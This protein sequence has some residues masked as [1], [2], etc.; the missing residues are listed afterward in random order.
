MFRGSIM[1]VH[2]VPEFLF[3]AVVN[4]PT[5]RDQNVFYSFL[6]GRSYYKPYNVIGRGKSPGGNL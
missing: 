5:V 1:H 2:A 4:Y 6:I 3:Q